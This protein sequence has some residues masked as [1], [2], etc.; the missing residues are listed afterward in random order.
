MLRIVWNKEDVKR[1]IQ[2]GTVEAGP[3]G[4]LT[5]IQVYANGVDIS[6][7]EEVPKGNNTHFDGLFLEFFH[8]FH[9]ID[10]EN[11]QEDN[12]HHISSVKNRVDGGSFNLY[13]YYN[14]ER[15]SLTLKYH[16][17]VHPEYRILEIDLRDFVDGVLHSS[18]EMLEEVLQLAP[19][20]REDDNYIALKEDMEVIRDWYQERYGTTASSPPIEMKPAATVTDDSIRWIGA[21]DAA[22]EE[23][24]DCVQKILDITYPDDYRACVRKH[25]MGFPYPYNI[26]VNEN[27]PG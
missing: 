18:I 9:S 7:L 14:E 1:G 12:F 2:S 20:L 16:N 3:I 24:I 6:G 5:P 13:I 26:I 15:D 8:I 25:S 4:F 21:E 23:M 11:L 17:F 10:P 27:I 22:D 19:E